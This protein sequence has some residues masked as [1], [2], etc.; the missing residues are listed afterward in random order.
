MKKGL[1]ASIGDSVSPMT[2]CSKT[3]ASTEV[4]PRGAKIRLINVVFLR[5]LSE[6]KLKRTDT[7]LD[8]SQKAKRAGEEKKKILKD[9]GR[10]RLI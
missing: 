10:E 6:I 9:G 7:T 3:C 5:T 8:L 2:L 4:S 1:F